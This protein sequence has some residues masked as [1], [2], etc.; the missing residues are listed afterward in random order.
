MKE[1]QEHEMILKRFFEAGITPDF[2][3]NAAD[4]KALEG[5]NCF[6]YI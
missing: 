3:Q 1:K 4:R 6:V 5:Q 2:A